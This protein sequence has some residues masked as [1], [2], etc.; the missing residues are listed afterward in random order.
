MS[1]D[2]SLNHPRALGKLQ[3]AQEQK[4]KRRNIVPGAFALNYLL[5]F[6]NKFHTSET[7]VTQ[8]IVWGKLVRWMLRSGTRCLWGWEPMC[9]GTTGWEKRE[10]INPL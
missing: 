8:M 6:N 3:T 1:G 2:R 9:S 4:M 5:S 7:E 10:K